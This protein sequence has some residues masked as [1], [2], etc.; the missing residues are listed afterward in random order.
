MTPQS[1][2]DREHSP[3][4]D[5]DLDVDRSR[6]VLSDDDGQYE[7]DI[8]SRASPEIAVS[9]WHQEIPDGFDAHWQYDHFQ[10]GKSAVIEWTKRWD[11]MHN[12]SDALECEVVAANQKGHLDDFVKDVTEHAAHGRYILQE[13][14]KMEGYIPLQM[15]KVR[16]LWR[17]S[18]ELVGILHQ[19]LAILDVRVSLANRG[20]WSMVNEKGL[21]VS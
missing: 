10:W 5:L 17:M 21:I 13:L 9:D 2:P 18:V 14:S 4:Q 12:W 1:T 3:S 16:E 8:D 15:W 20:R 19:G 11:G 6:G 7:D